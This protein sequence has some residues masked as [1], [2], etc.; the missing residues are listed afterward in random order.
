MVCVSLSFKNL[1]A[2]NTAK[3][4][5]FINSSTSKSN[6]QKKGKLPNDIEVK[7]YYIDRLDSW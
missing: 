7:R 5:K 2:P 1:M 3:N 6:Y 4:S